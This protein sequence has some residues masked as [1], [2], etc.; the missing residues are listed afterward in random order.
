MLAFM[1][2]L[3]LLTL[4]TASVANAAT[5]TPDEAVSAALANDPAL[6]SRIAAVDAAVGVRREALLFRNNPEV[7]VFKSTRGDRF[8]GKISQPLSLTG[9][10]FDASRSARAGV[11]AAEASAERARF[12]TAANA[13]RAYARAVLER[14]KLRFAEEDRN[15]LA[16]LRGVA[17]KRVAAGEGVDLDLRLARLEQARAMAAWLDAQ[18]DAS[19]A[20]ADLAA[21]IGATPGEL[22]H[23]PLVAIRAEPGGAS[24]RSDLVATQAATRAARAALARERSAILRPIELGVFY[25]RDD[26]DAIYG[27]EV[28]FQ[29]PIWQWN[30]SGIGAA[31]GN[32]RLAQAEEVSTAARAATEEARAVERLR[33][34]EESLAT[35]VPDLG[36]EAAPALRAIEGLF[37]SGE[38]NLSDTLLLRSRVV[39]GERAWMEARAAVAEARIDVALSRQSRVLLP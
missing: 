31:R 34:A 33:V 32:L 35:L 12:E 1:T 7:E 37:A 3:T 29:L 22:A 4:L 15:L 26:G 17:E 18:A 13:R 27:P 24:P 20:D 38:A 19:A 21:L 14:E 39:E 36:A 2:L 16:R 10:G 11:D 6:A 30:Q 8:A 28:T 9:E 25:E 5:L 23:D